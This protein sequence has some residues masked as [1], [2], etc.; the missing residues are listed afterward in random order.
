MIDRTK[1]LRERCHID[2]DEDGDSFVGIK[3]DS[4]D[5]VVYF[6]IGYQLPETE[7]EVKLDIKHLFAI[8]AAYTQ[9]EDRVL[10]MRKFEAP[11]SVD[12]PIKAYLDV[13]EYYINHGSY[14]ME[15]EPTYKVDTR[16]R[17]DWS[18]TIKNNIPQIQGNSVVYLKRTIR[19]SKPNESNLITEINKYCVY[20]SFERLGWLYSTDMPP[21]PSIDF[22]KNRFLAILRIKLNHTNNDEDRRLFRAM[23]AM[24]EFI[25]EKTLDKQFYFGTEHFEKVWE[26][27]IDVT[28]GIKEKE[29]YF[30]RTSWKERFGAKKNTPF[31]ALE[32]DSIM[33]IGDNY[34]VLD[35][36]YYRYGDTGM[37]GHLPEST[38]IN[39]QITY[40]EYVYNVKLNRLSGGQRLYNAFI[41]PFNMKSNPFGIHNWYGN[42]AE[43]IGDWR[44]GSKKAF[45]RIQ[46]IVIDVRYL[47]YHYQGNHDKQKNSLA[48]EIRKYV[49]MYKDGSD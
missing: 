26:R 35:A 2:T 1:S 34:F 15:T 17:T 10:H 47:M 25:D 31:H 33:V 28:F 29:E 18:R 27:L 24:I 46:G 44:G 11:Q 16:G 48:E 30:P 20:Q 7:H 43:A 49:D 14:Y 19:T 12:F 8:L 42:V 23:V 38:S 40:G 32:P 22:D 5:A 21:K 36:K 41:M 45:E 9:R 4:N 6:P 3:A 37:V 39:K 13:I